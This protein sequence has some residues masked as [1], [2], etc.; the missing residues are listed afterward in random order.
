MKFSVSLFLIAAFWFVM[1]FLTAKLVPAEVVFADLAVGAFIAVALRSRNG[2]LTVSSRWLN[3]LHEPLRT[4]P[5]KSEAT[6]LVSSELI[7]R[8][9]VAAN[10]TARENSQI[11]DEAI[12]VYLEDLEREMH[13]PA[14]S[15]K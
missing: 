2:R 3:F 13:E 9:N 8:L 6:F 15:V 7:N 11:V 14:G 4:A 5:L 10:R 12:S 1:A